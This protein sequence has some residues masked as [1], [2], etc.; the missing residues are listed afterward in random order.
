MAAPLL[1]L[2]LT[3]RGFGSAGR[4]PMCG[5]PHAAAG[6]YIRHL[7]DA[8]KRIALWDQTGEAVS[9]RLVERRVTRVLSAGTVIES[10]LLEPAAV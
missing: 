2:T 10:E 3:G 1:G 9:G 7:L 6:Q 4:V 8:G 5:F